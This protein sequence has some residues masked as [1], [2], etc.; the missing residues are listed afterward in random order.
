MGLFSTVMGDYMGT[1]GVVAR[2]PF[3]PSMPYKE[4]RP[5]DPYI[6]IYIHIQ[7]EK[8]LSEKQKGFRDGLSYSTP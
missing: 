3:F 1:T 6:Y 4:R 2:L 8:I 7:E 5:A